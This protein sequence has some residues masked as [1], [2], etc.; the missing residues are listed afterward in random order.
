ML[1]IILIL[2]AVPWSGEPVVA[3]YP[4]ASIDACS[5]ELRERLSKAAPATDSVKYIAGMCVVQSVPT[6]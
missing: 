6:S 2:I 3:D 5:T 1:K 4:M